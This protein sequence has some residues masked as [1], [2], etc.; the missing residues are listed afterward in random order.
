MSKLSLKWQKYAVELAIQNRIIGGIPTA[1]NLIE[2]W[3]KAHMPLVSE[4]ERA[5]L[6]QKTADE[7]HQATEEKAQGMWTTFKMDDEGPYLESRNVKAAFKEA[8]NILR[9]ML[10]KA[11]KKGKS[12]DG[13]KEAK[14][15]FTNLRSKLAE[16][17][18][19]AEDKLH[20]YRAGKK[21]V[22]VD[23]SEERAIHVMT[24]MGP[25]NALKRYDFIDGQ[26]EPTSVN[27][28]LKVLDDGLIE[29]ELIAVLLEYAGQNGLGA[30]R[31]Q[32]N[33]LFSVKK[34]KAI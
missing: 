23:G 5:T 1:P 4:D 26:G 19:I 27:F 14:S 9:S 2:G 29:E 30:D 22:K 31:S 6:A 24:A 16:R 28:T 34:L 13:K 15:R 20:F 11:E 12:E 18:F 3:L 21:L 32:G 8:A 10:E 7:L 33:G 17:L 25:R